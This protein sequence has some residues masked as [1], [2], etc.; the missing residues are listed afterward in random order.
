MPRFGRTNTLF[1]LRLVRLSGFWHSIGRRRLPNSGL[2][3]HSAA[4]SAA[5]HSPP[6]ARVKTAAERF[7][8][9]RKRLEPA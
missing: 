2:F 7:N 5:P 8:S 1:L 4:T 3:D 6:L 9:A